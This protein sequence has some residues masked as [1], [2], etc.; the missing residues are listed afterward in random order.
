MIFS[1]NW[2]ILLNNL[3]KFRA[4]LSVLNYRSFHQSSS[5]CLLSESPSRSSVLCLY[6][7]YL[8]IIRMASL[9][10]LVLVCREGNHWVWLSFN[11]INQE[12]W[13]H[14]IQWMWRNV[15]VTYKLLGVWDIPIHSSFIQ[16]RPS[17]FPPP[18]YGRFYLALVS[19]RLVMIFDSLKIPINTWCDESDALNTLVLKNIIP[20]LPGKNQSSSHLT[21][22]NSPDAGNS[23]ELTIPLCVQTHWR[24]QWS[25]SRAHMCYLSFCSTLASMLPKF[26]LL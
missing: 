24:I 6:P 15:G 3:R 17:F 11:S 13:H 25:P 26:S 9:L 22:R 23:S 10:F 8:R 21:S 12:L 2:V 16:T 19:A 20:T 4:L 7:G 18:L 5:H 1:G 14:Q